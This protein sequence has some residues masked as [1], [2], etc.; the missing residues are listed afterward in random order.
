MSEAG[1]ILNSAVN[2]VAFNL[3]TS[4]NPE[5]ERECL[6]QFAQGLIILALKYR[7]DGWGDL[8]GS[9]IIEDLSA[10]ALIALKALGDDVNFDEI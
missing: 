1:D 6:N 7:G 8:P 9:F 10:R 5:L 2:S 3:I 4:P